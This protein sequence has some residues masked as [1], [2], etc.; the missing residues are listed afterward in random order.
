MALFSRALTDPLQGRTPLRTVFWVY[1]VL[2]SVVYSFLGLLVDP[3]NPRF[4]RLY[5]VLGVA[6]G[7]VQSLMLWKCAYNTRSR[8][9][10]HWVRVSVV[11]GLIAIPFF[12]YLLYAYASLIV[13]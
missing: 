10:G 4:V 9:V 6:L 8:A 5:T 11:V 7:V 2:V 1:C 12:L 13:S 3:L